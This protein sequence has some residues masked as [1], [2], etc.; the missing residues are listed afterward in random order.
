MRL[1]AFR[2]CAGSRMD[3]VHT[4]H[5]TQQSA[6]VHH[7]N[8]LLVSE[9]GEKEK[10]LRWD[11]ELSTG[12]MPQPCVEIPPSA[13]TRPSHADRLLALLN[14]P[15]YFHKHQPRWK[16]GQMTMCMIPSQSQLGHSRWFLL[17]EEPTWTS[18]WNKHLI[19]PDQWPWLQQP[20]S[21]CVQK[22]GNKYALWCSAH[23]TGSDCSVP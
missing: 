10:V 1:R 8:W 15:G 9:G 4:A 11:S 13:S 18:V 17:Q 19:F 20:L 12:S 3:L 2:K 16:Q 7:Q 23:G 5:C 6:S 14:Q 21:W 22:D